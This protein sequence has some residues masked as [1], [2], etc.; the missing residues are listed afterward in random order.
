MVA[1]AAAE[2]SLLLQ[3]ASCMSRSELQLLWEATQ[4]Q[5]TPAVVEASR[6]RAVEVD[7]LPGLER[8]SAAL[9]QAIRSADSEGHLLQLWQDQSLNPLWTDAHRAAAAARQAEL[10]R[11]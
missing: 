11:A 2:R 8:T 5:W 10:R 1:A 7:R 9:W 3:V 4:R 6:Q